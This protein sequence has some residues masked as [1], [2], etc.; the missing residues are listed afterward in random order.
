[1]SRFLATTLL[2]IVV[3]TY[4]IRS[5]SAIGSSM[6]NLFGCFCFSHLWTLMI[7]IVFFAVILFLGKLN[8][9]MLRMEYRKFSISPEGL[10]LQYGNF[11]NK[12]YSWDSISEIVISAFGANAN[13]S[14]YKTVICCFLTPRKREFKNKVVSSIP[15][16]AKNT[17]NFVI[18][19][20]SEEILK[21]LSQYHPNIPDLRPEQIRG[22]HPDR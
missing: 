1:M 17:N 20:Y 21:E 8:I 5:I 3:I 2:P 15:Y 11:Q 14:N 16:C 13:R 7:N 19:D 4:L 10:T 6:M 22:F 18:I 9:N 12:T